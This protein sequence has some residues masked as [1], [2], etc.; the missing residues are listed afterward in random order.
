MTS[1]DTHT[2]TWTTPWCRRTDDGEVT[3]HQW[4]AYTCVVCGDARPTIDGR[5]G[6]LIR[7]TEE[8]IAEA[9]GYD[10]VTWATL[11]EV[12][13]EAVDAAMPVYTAD[14]ADLLADRPDLLTW[15]AD[16]EGPEWATGALRPLVA[17]TFEALHEH[18]LESATD[19]MA[20]IDHDDDPHCPACGEPIQFCPGHGEY[21]DPMGARTLAD[22]DS[23]DH[24]SC[25]PAGCDDHEWEE[26][27][28]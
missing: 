3:S 21:A 7:Q 22:H 4:F 8:A 19:W 17:A 6:R 28:R 11:P 27:T 1:T 18:V 25:H 14:Y 10:P 12:V 23:G 2:T 5:W 26:V 20:S 13:H 24:T 9:H 15:P 16:F